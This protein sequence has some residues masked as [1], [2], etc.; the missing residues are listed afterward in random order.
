ME[1]CTGKTI[2]QNCF[3][4]TSNTWIKFHPNENYKF[5]NLET[6]CKIYENFSID[7]F[8]LVFFYQMQQSLKYE[9]FKVFIQALN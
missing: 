2:T 4:D 1:T 6:I 9:Q 3:F 5:E 7:L 8:G